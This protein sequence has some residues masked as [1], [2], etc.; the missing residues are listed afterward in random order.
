MEAVDKSAF[1]FNNV[2]DICK[3][4]GKVKRLFTSENRP[5]GLCAFE[6]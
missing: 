3:L 6:I 5:K 4:T 2:S 1:S